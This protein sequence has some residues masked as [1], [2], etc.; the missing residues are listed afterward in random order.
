MTWKSHFRTKLSF[1]TQSGIFAKF[2]LKFSFSTR[3][4]IFDSNCHFRLKLSFSTQIDFFVSK[5]HFRLKLSFSTQTRRFWHYWLKIVLLTQNCN[6]LLYQK[7]RKW[8]KVNIFKKIE[9]CEI[10]HT[11]SKNINSSWVRK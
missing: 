3:I 4:V 1:S 8:P 5:W 6:N 7:S 2:W 9:T 11:L 10:F